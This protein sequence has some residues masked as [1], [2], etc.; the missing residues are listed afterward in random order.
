M[1]DSFLFIVYNDGTTK[2]LM[3]LTGTIPILFQGELLSWVSLYYLKKKKTF[4]LLHEFMETFF[5]KKIK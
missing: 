5:I 2:N 1:M 4:L 3:S